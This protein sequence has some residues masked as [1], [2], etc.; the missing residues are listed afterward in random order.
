MSFPISLNLAGIFCLPGYNARPALFGGALVWQQVE[1]AVAVFS[2]ASSVAVTWPS[3][4]SRAFKV[5]A[6]LPVL[7]GTEEIVVQVDEST[8]TPT[9]CTVL[10]NDAFTGEV[11]IEIEEVLS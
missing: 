1:Q 7:Y 4:G 11:A 10:A 9:G 2:S 8:I 3:F 6:S 5:K